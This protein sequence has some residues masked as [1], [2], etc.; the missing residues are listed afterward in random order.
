MNKSS[1]GQPCH[2]DQL[3]AG[4]TFPFDEK[5]TASKKGVD[6]KSVGSKTATT[7][8]TSSNGSAL[9]SM[10]F[11]EE[12]NDLLG[13]PSSESFNDPFHIKNDNRLGRNDPSIDDSA[14][15]R[16]SRN[17]APGKRPSIINRAK[18]EPRKGR[19]KSRNKKSAMPEVSSYNPILTPVSSR[20]YRST[21]TDPRSRE[22]WF[23]RRKGSE[24]DNERYLS[25]DRHFSSDRQF[26]SDFR[27]TSDR[28]DPYYDPLLSKGSRSSSRSSRL[29]ARYLKNNSRYM[30][31]KEFDDI[32]EPDYRMNFDENVTD[33]LSF[34]DDDRGPNISRNEKVSKIISTLNRRTNKL[35]KENLKLKNTLKSLSRSAHRQDDAMDFFRMKEKEFYH[36][37][38]GKDEFIILLE[39]EKDKLQHYLMESQIE[40]KI[41]KKK[42]ELLRNKVT[43]LELAFNIERSRN[44][45]NPGKFFV[46]ANN[47]EGTVSS[48]E[49]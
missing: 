43:D 21:T 28:D 8:V 30:Y 46:S 6:R 36:D 15:E 45:K 5:E 31:N 33:L 38:K 20:R 44:F 32:K 14:V 2:E 9:N 16:L 23:S 26:A 17:E 11:N 7:A 49:E 4:A 12:W 13:L 1:V 10:K 48:L 18:S 27:L 41:L 42:C 29:S 3:E 22:S 47:D 40:S 39:R 37:L 35:E 19:N 25:S 24:M 34:M